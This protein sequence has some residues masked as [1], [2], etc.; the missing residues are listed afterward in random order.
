[1]MGNDRERHQ[2]TVKF[3]LR[4]HKKDLEDILAC[5]KIQKNAHDRTNSSDM[6]TILRK[7]HW[8]W[9]GMFWGNQLTTSV[10]LSDGEQKVNKY[11]VDP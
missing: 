11:R 9:I 3:S 10:S 7:Y 8:R 4:K 5:N 6:R 1:M 2:Q